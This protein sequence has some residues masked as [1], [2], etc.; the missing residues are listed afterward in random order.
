MKEKY[1]HQKMKKKL[2]GK[3]RK[4][5][6]IKDLE[7]QLTSFHIHFMKDLFD[8]IHEYVSKEIHK[9]FEFNMAEMNALR[10]DMNMLIFQY[11]KVE[12]V[13]SKSKEMG[14]T[15]TDCKKDI[16][17]LTYR[18]HIMAWVQHLFENEEFKK[19]IL[20]YQNAKKENYSSFMRNEPY[21]N[22]DFLPADIE[23]EKREDESKEE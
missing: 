9:E 10:N 14:D 1:N 3:I 8:R 12:E 21:A 19:L 5:N 7:T 18:I 4:W 15:I 23:R 22:M 2:D 6:Q 13:F 11:R 20:N 16:Y 17:E